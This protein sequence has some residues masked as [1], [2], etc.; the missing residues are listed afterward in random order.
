MKK[1]PNLKK[2]EKKYRPIPFWSWNEKLQ[3]DETIRQVRVMDEIGMGG[4]FMHA[5]GGLQTEYMGE[6]WFENIESATKEAEERGMYSWAYDENGW[7]S[8]FG[9][10]K[11]NGL[12]TE[13]QQKYLRM[14]E[15][16]PKENVIAKNGTH[17]FYYDVN[18][19]YTDV[20]DKKVVKKFI[21]VVYEPYYN[22]YKNRITGFF[23]DE[24][25]ISRNGI[26]WSFVFEKEYKKLYGED[27]LLNLEKLFLP[28]GDYKKVRVNFWKMVTDL[29]TNSYA[30]QVYDWCDERGLK[31]TGHM[32]EEE[33][34][35][36]QVTTSGA[37]MPNYEYFHI[38]GMDWLGRD[39]FD[40]L[41]PIQVSSAAEQL[42]KEQVL[43]ETYALCGHNVSF[44]E[45][46]GIF[47]WQMVH[48]INLLCQHL[49]G[50][51]LRGIRK[52]DFPP[53]MYFQQPWW[54]EYDKF[55]DAVSRE[56]KI[57]S[58]GKKT[59]KVL[60]IHPQTTVWTMFD[61]GENKG[62]EELNKKFLDVIKKLE[63]KHIVYHLGDETI[64]ERHAKVKGKSIV[65]GEMEYSCILNP[66][67][68]VLL[69]STQKLLDEFTNNGGKLTDV[70]S[71]EENKV[72]D[73]KEI[74][75]TRRDY[76][77]GTVH[78]F[79]NTSPNRKKAKLLVDGKR[80]NILTGDLQDCDKNIEFEPWGSVM[81]LDDEK[82][83][84]EENDEKKP[85][86]IFF[87]GEFTISN[88]VE[89]ALTLDFCDYY[90][91]GELQEKQGYVLNI[92]D[93]ANSLKRPVKIHQDYFFTC[94]FVPD[95][96]SLVVET[97]EIFDI[98]L[99]GKK[100]DKR[101][102]GTYKDPSFKKIDISKYVMKGKNTLSFDC[103]FVQSEEVYKNI[104]NSLEFE[105][106]SNKLS[107]I[108]EIE[109]IY[110][111]GDFSVVTDEKWEKTDKNAYF[112]E[113][114]FVISKPASK[115]T[116]SNIEKQ[117]FPFFSGSM[118]LDGKINIT[119]ENP[120][121]YMSIKG[122]N[123][124]KIEINGIEKTL[125]FNDRL[126]L[127]EFKVSGETKVKVTI[128]NNLRN[129]LG[130]HHLKEGESHFVVRTHFYKEPCVFI[131]NPEPWDD[132]YCFVETGLLEK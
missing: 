49:Q 16:E 99:N 103:D 87:D 68:E 52:R 88:K 125:L 93:R 117:G 94:D 17:W 81:I 101:I 28:I 39:I 122:I 10:G 86:K 63:Q 95:E 75:Y 92:E 45:L 107:F 82:S 57:L 79:V 96:I 24:P 14:S 119:G 90:F 131:K 70:D 35:K 58:S 41:T 40:C 44:S 62:I 71:L 66:C 85:D 102:I 8:G 132:R 121:L 55:I 23:T 120:V 74:T 100:V 36:I 1:L 111:V 61:N 48:G 22:K 3:K 46:K 19:F 11:V 12:G 37:V 50:Y 5:R 115:I 6:E 126:D 60:L 106:E 38:P 67:G 129:L 34:F 118:S 123:A 128:I 2:I 65:I 109:P 30:K 25:Q 20:L 97:P 113:G 31:L 32:V 72:I 80:I 47:E 114:D 43:S 13:Y 77:D 69:K 4:F 15:T 89:N 54:S 108:T 33:N 105:S 53:A 78:F 110:I 112:Y 98:K 21:E 127:K 116:L 7:P 27:L 64:M 9:N 42:G 73:N 83:R 51:S 59:P 18:P 26:P 124:V 56:G 130:P 104:K 29:F 91:D 84:C 76:E